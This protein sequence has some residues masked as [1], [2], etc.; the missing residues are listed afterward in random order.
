MAYSS[1]SR[2]VGITPAYAGKRIPRP[3]AK[4]GT[5]DHPRVCG[6]KH[7]LVVAL[8]LHL[9][10]P[11]RMRG[12]G[13]QRRQELVWTGIT[14]AYAGKRLFASFSVGNTWDHPR[15]CGEKSSARCT[16]PNQEGS[17]PRMRG[18]EVEELPECD[19][20]GITPAY[21]GKR[22]HRQRF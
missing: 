6:E 15:V 11:P 9:G 19:Y 12:K 5:R 8:R 4:S 21:A 14:P 20:L 18:K 7:S 13:R 17:P 2:W 10:S 16:S 1:V 3:A 22:I